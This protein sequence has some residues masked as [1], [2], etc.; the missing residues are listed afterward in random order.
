MF[1]DCQGSIL[2][3]G[4]SRG[5][6]MHI[7]WDILL[8]LVSLHVLSEWTWT[9]NHSHHDHGMQ[10]DCEGQSSLTACSMYNSASLPCL[11]PRRMNVA[12][13][14]HTTPAL[15]VSELMV[16]RCRLLCSYKSSAADD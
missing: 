7:H 13:Q 16:P 1:T 3:R 10:H 9:M 15:V 5:T 8:Q 11:F 2:P 14:K 12:G 4:M 6:G